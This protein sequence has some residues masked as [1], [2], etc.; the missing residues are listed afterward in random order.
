MDGREMDGETG[1]RLT[2]RPRRIPLPVDAIGERATIR[3]KGEAQVRNTGRFAKGDVILG[4]YEVVAELGQGGMGVVYKCFDKTGG[5]EVAVK[6]LPPDVSHDESSMEDIR[7]NFQLVSDLRHP[8]IVGIKNLESDP[9]TG[10]Y[11][12]VMDLASGKNLH[13]WAKTHRGPES[14][15]AKLRI[16]EEIAAALDYA[17]S[18][19]VMHRDIKPENVM[20][21]EDG[22]AHILDF[23]LAS[24][25]R[26][27]M[28]RRSLVVRS[29][30]GTPTYKAPEQWRG[31]PQSAATDQYSLGVLAYELV[32]GHLPFDS[33]D[34]TILRASVLSEPVA[35]V[36][37]APGHV[38]AA[39]ARALSKNPAR[40]FASCAEF[41]RALSGA[42]P[43]EAATGAGARQNGSADSRPKGGGNG[44][45]W[46]VMA[47]VAVC[48]AA[49]VAY[50]G[51]KARRR[52]VVGVLSTYVKGVG[53]SD[54]PEEKSLEDKALDAFRRDDYRAGY[55]YAMSTDRTHPKLQCYIGMCYDQQEPRSSSMKI[56]KDD[57]VAKE[58]YEKSANQGDARAMTYMGLFLEN[59]R[60]GDKDYARAEEWFRKA[61]ATGYPEGRANLLRLRKKM[62]RDK[63]KEVW[64]AGLTLPKYP[65][66]ISTS[67][68]NCW[69]I[70]DGYVKVNP[71]GG[72]LSPVVWKPGWQKSPTV[73]AG[74]AEGTWLHRKTCPNCM[75]R[76]TVDPIGECRNCGGS[77]KV[78][79]GRTCQTCKGNRTIQRHYACRA[80]G[81]KRETSGT[82]DI[83]KGGGYGICAKC[84]GRGIVPGQGIGRGVPWLGPYRFRRAQY[85]QCPTCRGGRY[86]PCANCKGQRTATK[87][88]QACKGSGQEVRQEYCQDCGGNGRVNVSVACPQCRNGYLGHASPCSRCSGEGFVWE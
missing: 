42:A 80:C 52:G 45:M 2:M 15:A 60:G 3:P 74:V 41:A 71:N 24:Q 81:G 39:L 62:M 70:E 64:R 7:D 32:A 10:D 88:C 87:P 46:A 5:I 22:H 31:Q 58:W 43:A 28:S 9:A 68:T 30:S 16:V 37:G 57:W 86:V 17:H 47:I 78:T 6:G 72:A 79:V 75:G 33:E 26:T 23:G 4:R 25:I 53:E 35:P 36:P 8:G 48:L 59:G 49:A 34:T 11:Y 40:R 67:T 82:C 69:R 38:N 54:P 85:F 29:E 27:S 61:A 20:I 73:K 65:H 21:D 66:W 50:M 77:G 19:R 18:R 55:A 76:K 83:C 84:G 14:I 51:H 12:L 63:A 13:R 44:A 56:A 1:R